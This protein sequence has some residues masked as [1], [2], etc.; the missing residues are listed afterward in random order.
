MTDSKER[1][2]AEP[3]PVSFFL[4]PVDVLKG[5]H[6]ELE[7]LLGEPQ[8]SQV[9]YRC[10][11]R[12][13][14]SVVKDMRIRFPDTATLTRSL[15]ELWLQMGL[16]VIDIEEMRDDGMLLNCS[17]SNEALAQGTTGE[18]SCDLTSGYLAGMITTLMEARFDSVEE[19]CASEGNGIGCL[20]RLTRMNGA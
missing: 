15:P 8:A 12:S 10:G 14:K 17:D 6:E 18:K 13:G 7:E 16:G 20:F 1:A 19:R 4:M 3:I 9:I 5:I 11:F 2:I